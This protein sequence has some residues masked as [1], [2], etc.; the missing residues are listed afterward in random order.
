[1]PVAVVTDSTAYLPSE[2]IEQY[3]IEVVPLYVVLAGRSGREGSEIGPDDVARALSAR[4][5]SVSTSRP[6]PGD[7]VS[8]YR[9]RLHR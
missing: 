5:K 1:V 9:R 2:L 8:Y 6:T 3:D 7:F 4:G